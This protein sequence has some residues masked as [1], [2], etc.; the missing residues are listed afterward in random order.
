[1]ITEQRNPKRLR[2]QRDVLL[3]AVYEVARIECRRLTGSPSPAFRKTVDTLEEFDAAATPMARTPRLDG[4]SILLV[5]DNRDNR[6]LLEESLS[7]FGATVRTASNA[8][9]ALQQFKDAPS[10]LVVTDVAMPG[11]SGVWLLEQLRS[12]PAVGQVRVIAVTGRA[13]PDEQQRLRTAGFD[14]LMVKPL[15]LDDL[16]NAITAVARY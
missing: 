1:M 12:L 11:R 2:R 6:E 9:D 8:E 4:L 3:E 15:D 5:D 13:L 7:H 10:A 14:A 16:V